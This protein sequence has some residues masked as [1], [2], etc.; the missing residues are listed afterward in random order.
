MFAGQP[1]G[2]SWLVSMTGYSQNTIRTGL[3]FLERTQIILRNGRYDGFVLAN[4]VVQLPLSAEQLNAGESKIDSRPLSTTTTLNNNI[5][6]LSSSSNTFNKN[7]ANTD[8]VSKPST[9]VIAGESKNDSH[10]SDD[11]DND[12]TERE[13]LLFEAGINEPKRSEIL[14]KKW[15]T[16]DYI[17]AHIENAKIKEIE[18]GL[19]IHKMLSHDLKPKKH[20]DN[21]DPSRYRAW[22][23]SE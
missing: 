6:I 11:L 10:S 15:C 18:T 8:L 16:E 19:L 14:E 17:K 21:Q 7:K 13:K 2:E 12:L 3:K 5:N 23:Q 20:Y 1:V 22:L 9:K 4:G